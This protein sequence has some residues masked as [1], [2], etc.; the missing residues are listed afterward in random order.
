MGTAALEV[1]SFIGK[2]MHLSSCGLRASLQFNCSDGNVSVNLT[3]ELGC[4]I[5]TMTV[6]NV[7]KDV[8]PSQLRRRQR[9]KQAREN[10]AVKVHE[11][12]PS[13]T[14]PSQD[15]SSMEV[16]EPTQPFKETRP[17][18]PPQDFTPLIDQT[19]ENKHM[20]TSYAYLPNDV[21]TTTTSL[22]PTTPSPPDKNCCP[23]CSTKRSSARNCPGPNV[24]KTTY[25]KCCFHK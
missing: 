8:K 20:T 3:A 1:S 13:S 4:N 15:I 6:P 5:P 21:T 24:S 17:F 11:P 25:I 9:R 16:S 22:S 2:F 12:D 7:R 14:Q 10:T 18:S 23:C 19:S